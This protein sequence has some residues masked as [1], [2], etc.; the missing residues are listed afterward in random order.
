M[1]LTTI[2]YKNAKCKFKK[3]YNIVYDSLSGNQYI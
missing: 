1:A 3:K 2:R